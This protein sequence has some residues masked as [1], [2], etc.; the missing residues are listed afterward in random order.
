MKPAN[1]LARGRRRP[2]RRRQDHRLRQRLQPRRRAHAGLPRRLAGLHV[3]RA[4][5]RRRARLPRRHLLA[6]RACCTT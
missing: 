4:A 2:G 3:A 5:R 1:L 6:G